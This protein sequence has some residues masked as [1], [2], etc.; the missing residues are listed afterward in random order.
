MYELGKVVK[1]AILIALVVGSVFGVRSCVV[2]KDQPIAETP[3]AVE[4]AVEVEKEPVVEEEAASEVEEEVP[5]EVE[6]VSPAAPVVVEADQVYHFSGN[7]PAYS[8][9]RTAVREPGD[10]A[11]FVWNFDSG[12]DEAVLSR[13]W[14]D[15]IL[16]SATLLIP[17]Q[18]PIDITEML[19]MFMVSAGGTGDAELDAVLEERGVNIEEGELLPQ[20]KHSLALGDIPA[21]SKIV[22]EIKD[23]A[24]KAVNRGIG[25]AVTTQVDAF[26]VSVQ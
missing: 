5:T 12:L 23:D 19:E 14:P 2:N 21:G 17:G 25:V 10:A 9:F 7:A 11:T 26:T 4:D 3:A 18:D 8:D 24:E 15:D 22:F 20:N 13:V 6:E 1:W 16:V